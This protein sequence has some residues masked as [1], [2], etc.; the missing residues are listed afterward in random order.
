MRQLQ[1][2]IDQP[3]LLHDHQGR[4]MHGVAAKVA[5]KIRV[6]LQNDGLDAGP[7]QQKPQHHAGR[8]TAGDTALNSQRV[9]HT[10]ANIRRQHRSPKP[11]GA[12][13]S[14]A[15]PRRPVSHPVFA[16]APSW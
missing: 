8:S 14:P 5:Q 4:G 12:R 7:S 16:A 6:L 10:L 1:K 9:C 15:S 3:Q 13:H 11:G 2:I